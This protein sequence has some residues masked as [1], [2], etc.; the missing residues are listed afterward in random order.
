MSKV[1]MG[2]GVLKL[3]WT[4]T[5]SITIVTFCCL[6]TW[7]RNGPKSPHFTVLGTWCYAEI[8]TFVCFTFLFFKFYF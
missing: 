8:L 2:D 1:D 3:Q 5:N 7:L 4:S 6:V